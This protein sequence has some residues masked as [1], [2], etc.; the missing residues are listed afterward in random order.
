MIIY[1]IINEQNNPVV[2]FHDLHDAALEAEK[3]NHREEDH[4]FYVAELEREEH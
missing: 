4:Y 1:Q 2:E 3:L